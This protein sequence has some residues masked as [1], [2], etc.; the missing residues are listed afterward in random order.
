[1]AI[2]ES[3]LTEAEGDDAIARLNVW[4]ALADLAVARGD[5]APFVKM[6]G[7]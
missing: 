3:V 7:K 1:V 6:L 5:V 2:A 4:R